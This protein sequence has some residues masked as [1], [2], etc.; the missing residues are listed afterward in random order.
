MKERRA[1][2]IAF[3]VLSEY[4][5]ILFPYFIVILKYNNLIIIQKREL[6]FIVVVAYDCTE[7][8]YYIYFYY[9]IIFLYVYV[10]KFTMPLVPFT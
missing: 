9:S 2:I 1:V 4:Y 3:C 5:S 10:L 8:I 7:F 6:F